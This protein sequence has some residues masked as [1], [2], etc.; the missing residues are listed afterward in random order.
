[1]LGASFSS[2][3][4]DSFTIEIHSSN[5]ENVI[6]KT[7]I[8][9]WINDVHIGLPFIYAKSVKSGVQKYFENQ[10]LPKGQIIFKCAAFSEMNSSENMFDRLTKIICTYLF[11][12]KIFEKDEDYISLF[13]Q[14][15]K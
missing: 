15:L 5:K 8:H 9:S 12:D 13:P 1:M 6:Y 10:E 14:N 3:S 4:S 2:H 11:S 7:P